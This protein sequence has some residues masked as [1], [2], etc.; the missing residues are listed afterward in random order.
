MVSLPELLVSCSTVFMQANNTITGD[1]QDVATVLSNRPWRNLDVIKTPDCGMVVVDETWLQPMTLPMVRSRMKASLV[2]ST[3][4]NENILYFVLRS[5]KKL[6]F[7]VYIAT[8]PS[9]VNSN[10]GE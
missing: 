6:N 2:V 7:N 5:N 4:T 3:R 9:S 1:L 8:T 10:T